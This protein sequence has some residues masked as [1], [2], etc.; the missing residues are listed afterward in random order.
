MGLATAARYAEVDS[1][2]RL[3]RFFGA[4]LSGYLS[5]SEF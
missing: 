1:F 2:M 5:N 3:L 4:N